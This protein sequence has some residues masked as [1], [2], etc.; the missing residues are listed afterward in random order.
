[1]HGNMQITVTIYAGSSKHPFGCSLKHIGGWSKILFEKKNNKNRSLDFFYFEFGIIRGV[2][3]TI[4][5]K[6]EKEE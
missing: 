1:M 5:D 3:K 2:Q 6:L 4:S